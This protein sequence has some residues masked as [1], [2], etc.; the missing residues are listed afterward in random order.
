M[1]S[2]LVK[3]TL[4]SSLCTR[5]TQVEADTSQAIPSRHDR[6]VQAADR[7]LYIVQGA[8]TYHYREAYLDGDFVARCA[9]IHPDATRCISALFSTYLFWTSRPISSTGAY[10]L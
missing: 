4:Q 10:E 1:A 2:R 8:S 9:S 3:K 6:S 5:E 7:L